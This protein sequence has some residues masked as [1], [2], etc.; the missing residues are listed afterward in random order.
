[1][2]D[3]DPAGGERLSRGS[4]VTITVGQ[5]QRRRWTRSRAAPRRPRRDSV[6]HRGALMRVAI[7]A[8][9]R[10]SEHD[11]SLSSAASVR[12]GVAAAGHEVVDITIARV[13]RL[14]ARRRAAGAGPRRRA[15]RRRRGVPG[16][17]RPV[18]RGRHG[19]G[20]AGAARRALRRRRRARL[21]AV[22]G[23]GRLQGGAGGGRACRR[24]PTPRC[25]SRAGRRSRPRCATSWRRWGCPCSSS[26]RGSAR[27]WASSRSASPTRSTARWRPRS[28][29]TGW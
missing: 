9:G 4:R 12:E 22:H 29:T 19:P 6:A 11:V 16:P 3:Q 8:G 14:A 15:A 25:A 1:M 10:S 24:S 13:G 18:R 7:L 27:R 21:G 28:A 26:R 20:A 2:V 5:V 23:Q 17:A